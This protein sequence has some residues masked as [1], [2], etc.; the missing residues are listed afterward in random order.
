MLRAG[1][2]HLRFSLC[3]F[4]ALADVAKGGDG[5]LVGH[6]PASA[7]R[8]R[9]SALREVFLRFCPERVVRTSTYCAWAAD[10]RPWQHNLSTE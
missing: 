6:S 7:G 4:A 2:S 1:L 3:A 8:R 10:A 5:R 9:K